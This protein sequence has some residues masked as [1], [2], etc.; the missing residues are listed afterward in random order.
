GAGG[1]PDLG[2]GN[3]FAQKSCD[4]L[5]A[6]RRGW[7]RNGSRRSCGCFR[8]LAAHDGRRFVM[9]NG[10]WH[11]GLMQLCNQLGGFLRD[12]AKFLKNLTCHLKI[13]MLRRRERVECAIAPP[14]HSPVN[15]DRRDVDIDCYLKNDED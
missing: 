3:T 6:I 2:M 7:C 13:A 14:L 11:V 5:K 4:P 9:L 1:M 8:G 10:I 12:R 15:D